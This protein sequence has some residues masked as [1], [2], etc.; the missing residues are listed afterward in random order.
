MLLLL[1]PRCSVTPSYPSIISITSGMNDR[2]RGEY[3]QFLIFPNRTTEFLLY[4]ADTAL[5]STYSHTYIYSNSIHGGGTDKRAGLSEFLSAV[6]DQ[7]GSRKMYSGVF[8]ACRTSL[9]WNSFAGR[10]RDI[11][12]EIKV[13]S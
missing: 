2:K 12:S 4:V 6:D 8:L 7:L 3:A 1:I 13:W 5:I 11:F 9:R 10:R